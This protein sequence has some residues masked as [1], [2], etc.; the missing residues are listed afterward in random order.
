[1]II[2]TIAFIYLFSLK[3]V[4]STAIDVDSLALEIAKCTLVVKVYT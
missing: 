2:T 3:E 4:L 1:M